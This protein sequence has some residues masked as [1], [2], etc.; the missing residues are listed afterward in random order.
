MYCTVTSLPHLHL[1]PVLSMIARGPTLPLRPHRQHDTNHSQLHQYVT[2][3]YAWRAFLDIIDIIMLQYY[4]LVAAPQALGDIGCVKDQS[5]QILIE[6]QGVLSHVYTRRLRFYPD[7]NTPICT[8]G[9]GYLDWKPD[10]NGG[11]G[12]ESGLN[13]G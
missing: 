10:H 7:W 9:L 13:P 4:F 12:K 1:R 11:E 6:N 3:Y 5:T 2:N 8:C